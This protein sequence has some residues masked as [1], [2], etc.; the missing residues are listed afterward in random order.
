[1]SD[2]TEYIRRLAAG[3][4]VELI[5]NNLDDSNMVSIVSDAGNI[6]LP[7]NELIDFEKEVARI[8]TEIEQTKKE[9][10]KNRGSNSGF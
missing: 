9:I 3:E 8:E 4:K 7:M 2:C 6:Y 10:G 1:M 5:D